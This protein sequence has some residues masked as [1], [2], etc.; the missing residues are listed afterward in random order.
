MLGFY[1]NLPIGGLAIVIFAFIRVPENMKK[2]PF[3]LQL[4]RKV[5]PELDLTGFV[6]FVPPA[7]ML[8]LALQ[9]G[10]GNTF[11][12]NSATIIGLFVGA[13]V[14]AV[15]FIFYSSD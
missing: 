6:L 14:S 4:I 10:S 3:S 12:W 8:L 7:V 1:I 13:A 11:A 5:I 2:D 9:Y 15:I